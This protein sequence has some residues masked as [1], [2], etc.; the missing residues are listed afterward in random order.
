MELVEVARNLC[1][2]TATK[3]VFLK[4]I[5]LIEFQV[6]IFAPDSQRLQLDARVLVAIRILEHIQKSFPDVSDEATLTELLRL[7]EYGDIVN[8]V[9]QSGGWRRIRQLWS[10][11]EFDEQLAIRVDEAKAV[12]RLADFSYR[13]AKS[14]PNGSRKA[15]PTMARKCLNE[16]NKRKGGYSTGTLKNRWSEYGSA[17]ALQYVL[18]IQKIGPKLLKVNK[19]NFVEKLISQTLE[20]DSLRNFFAAYRDV[21]K[22][23]RPR[24]YDSPLLALNELNDV[25]PELP[26]KEFSKKM[27]EII[28]QYKP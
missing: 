21:S 15:G 5:E 23:L 11:R 18:L 14:M 13:F 22:V 10:A 27:R 12:A 26:V 7:P 3:S 6:S 28:Q 4:A 16:F 1:E 25:K 17:A 2:T 19:V 8:I 24:G 20:V 9:F